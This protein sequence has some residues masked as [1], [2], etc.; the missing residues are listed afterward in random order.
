MDA[1]REKNSARHSFERRTVTWQVATLLN[2]AIL[3]TTVTVFFF[4]RSFVSAGKSHRQSPNA[5]HSGDLRSVP[6]IRP[7]EDL[8]F[9]IAETRVDDFGTIAPAEFYEVLLRATPDELASLA[10][11]F[12]QL[13]NNSRTMAAI[14]MFF[15]AWAELDAKSALAG[16]FQ[17]RDVSARRMAANTVVHSASPSVSP[18]L[19]AFVVGYSGKDFTDDNRYDLLDSIIS[20]WADLDPAAAANFLEALPAATAEMR[21]NTGSNIAF[22]WGTLDPNA[23]LQWVDRQTN[24]PEVLFNSVVNGWSKSDSA[25]AGAYVVQHIDQP[26]AF[27]AAS[28]VALTMLNEDPNKAAKWLK[29]LPAGE[30]RTNAERAFAYTWADRDPLAA[31]QWAEGLEMEDRAMAAGTIA[32]IWKNRDWEEARQ[33]L[34]TISG[35]FRDAAIAGA[36]NDVYQGRISPA[37]ALP[38]ALS[39]M[40]RQNRNNVVQHVIERW[41]SEEPQAAIDWIQGSPLSREEKQDLLALDVFHPQRIERARTR[42]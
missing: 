18:D 27:E 20:R 16:A 23:A 2:L 36:L 30:V 31:A 37:E 15:Q 22:S 41:G 1:N 24:N 12:N 3:L 13:P 32:N 34:G 11:R 17:M 39:M 26:G 9:E 40:D 33:W 35:D 19:A 28:S 14:G 8:P 38:L 4:N 21:Y 42:F 10:L 29:Q 6:T 25:A 7:G 5:Y